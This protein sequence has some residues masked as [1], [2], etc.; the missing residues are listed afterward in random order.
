[1][2]DR[3]CWRARIA[4]RLAD[5]RGLSTF[6]LAVLLVPIVLVLAQAYWN[7]AQAATARAD[8]RAALTAGLAAAA[9]QGV[10]DHAGQPGIG[11]SI[12]NGSGISISNVTFSGSGQNLKISITGSGFGQAP[13]L[14]ASSLSSNW[15]K[16]DPACTNWTFS[17][18]VNEYNCGFFESIARGVVL[19]S[20][21]TA[22]TTIT[23]PAGTEK[24]LSLQTPS[25][26]SDSNW[27]NVVGTVT[28]TNAATGGTVASGPYTG[29]APWGTTNWGPPII[30]WESPPLGPGT[31]RVTVTATEYINLYGLWARPV[32]APTATLPYTG[33]TASFAFNDL[34]RSW[35]GGYTNGGTDQNVV[36]MDYQSWSPTQIVLDGFA[37]GYG[38]GA[39][40]DQLGD[41]VQL[42]VFNPQTGQ[43]ASWTGTLADGSTQGSAAGITWSGS[44]ASQAAIQ[45]IAA[46]LRAQVQAQG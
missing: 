3:K 14:P 7:Y 39:W 26:V 29:G 2:R 27:S 42:T 21:A 15:T 11:G 20:G 6:L 18:Q 45:A 32:Q 44:A 34:S 9:T 1:M 24:Q 46:D 12:Q 35:Q 19:Y 23:V 41:Q 13:E 37:G 25:Y 4:R 8:L 36:T 38:Q 28:V 22:T 16:V 31:Y 10:E 5:R 17:G 40:V 43:Q 33:D 30:D